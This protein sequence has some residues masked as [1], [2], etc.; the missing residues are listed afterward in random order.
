MRP[1]GRSDVMRFF[2]TLH[3]HHTE[4]AGFLKSSTFKA[5]PKQAWPDL[6]RSS[7]LC[8]RNCLNFGVPTVSKRRKI[9]AQA[10]REKSNTKNPMRP[11]FTQGMTRRAKGCATE[12]EAIIAS[13][14]L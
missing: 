10:V 11:A 5:F 1:D 7:M 2:R 14:T 9:M 3:V 6:R 12:K 8:S 13:G 4:Y